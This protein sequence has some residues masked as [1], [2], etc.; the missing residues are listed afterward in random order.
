MMTRPPLA[1]AAVIRVSRGNF[2]PVRFEEV[3]AMTRRTGDYLIPAIRDLDGLAGYFAG[4]SPTG[5]MVHVSFWESN[6]HAE[7]MGLLKQMTADA[8]RE[9]EAVAC[10][11]FRSS[12][13]RSP[14]RFRSRR[15]CRT[16]CSRCEASVQ[17]LGR[18]SD[19][20]C[21]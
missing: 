16:S 6:D 17:A 14:G 8:R 18:L 1:E 3:A 10:R 9:A 19:L 2:D 5:S 4:A 13:T 21:R 7:Q 20:G 15:R 11:S 12:T